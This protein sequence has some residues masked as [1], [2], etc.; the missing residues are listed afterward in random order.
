MKAISRAVRAAHVDD[1]HSQPR[2][3]TRDYEN[4]EINNMR[5]YLLMM[6]SVSPALDD[7][8]K[9]V[10]LC[11]SPPYCP[12]SVAWCWDRRYDESQLKSGSSS[13]DTRIPGSL[14]SARAYPFFNAST[15]ASCTTVCWSRYCPALLAWLLSSCFV[16]AVSNIL[17]KLL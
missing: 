4:Y 1:S 12:P 13:T 10:L 11:Y 8:A 2:R 16:T 14:A 6:F 15:M 3:K 7:A 5:I 9:V 17:H